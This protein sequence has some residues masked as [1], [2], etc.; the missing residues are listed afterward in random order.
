MVVAIALVVLAQTSGPLAGGAWSSARPPECAPLDT[1]RAANVWERAK[2]PELRR[3]CDLLASGASKLAGS[4]A[5]AREVV[6]IADEA[7]KLVASK[8]AALVL[9]GRAL[10]QLGSY[11]DAHKAL[12]EARARDDRA[13]DDPHALL[14]WARVLSRSG[15]PLEAADAYRALLPRASMLTLAERSGAE[16]EAGVLAMSRGPASLDEALPIL[17]QAVRDAQD[18][19]QTVA[20]LALALALDRAGDRDE[21]R[22]LLAERMRGDPRT[23]LGGARAK[24]LLGPAGAA[25]VGALGAMG[26]EATDPVAA[27]AEWARYLEANG[28]EKRPW[29]EHARAHVA[30]LAGK[31][32]KKKP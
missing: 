27:R 15:R 28:A 25:E 16:I 11:S 18:V 22:A 14:A 7:D 8:A 6:A 5:L 26:L 30:A 10:A 4:T 9:K 31:A 29:L 17:R 21:A 2:A 20:V 32:P 24:D 12:S 13:L 1:G 23:S 3:Y 19:A